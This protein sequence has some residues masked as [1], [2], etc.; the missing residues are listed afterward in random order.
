MYRVLTGKQRSLVFP[1]MCNACVK[2]DYSDNIPSGVDGSTTTDDITYGIWGHKDS[3]TIE[4]LVTPYDVNGYG[5]H[6][7][8]SAIVTPPSTEKIM[9]APTGDQLAS[10]AH[11]YLSSKYMTRAERLV[12]QMAIFHSTK[13]QLYLVNTTEHNENNPAE[14][15]IRFMVNINGTAITLDSPTVFTSVFG[16]SLTTITGTQLVALDVDGKVKYNKHPYNIATHSGATLTY[17][18]NQT[19]I[20]HEGQELFILDGFATK[21]IGTISTL[22]YDAPSATTTIVLDAPYT[23]SLVGQSVYL[24]TLKHPAYISNA[25]H[26]AATYN[27]ISREMQIYYNNK[28]VASTFHTNTNEFSF[29]KE[30][31]FL[32]ANGNSATGSQTAYTNKQF[33][34][35]LHEFAISGVAST[36][37]NA[38]N[39]TP[40]YANTLLYFRFE[41]VDE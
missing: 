31:F 9:P 30:D 28:L 7:V 23:T 40:R 10:T 16:D 15:K 20:L 27:D 18:S 26:I 13:V 14:Y 6:S 24:P 2:I 32:G 34:G 5:R 4:A 11:H 25:S 21:L 33:M 3:F 35:E 39:L 38:F 1:I 8:G 12:H 41:E 37:F 17:A 36:I 22:T 19:T 29:D